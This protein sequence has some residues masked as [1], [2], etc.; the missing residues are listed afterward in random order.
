[1]SQAKSEIAGILPRYPLRRFFRLLKAERRDITYLYT[2]AVLTG[3]ISLSLPLGIQAIVNFV[4]GGQLSTSW[5]IL[6]LLVIVGVIV[7]GFLQIMQLIISETIQQRIFTN[8]A[9]EFAFRIPRMRLEA[10]YKHYAPELVNR[11]FDTLNVQKGLSKILLDLSSSSLQIIFGLILLSFYH[12]LFIFFGLGLILI[13]Y[14]IIRITGPLGFKSSLQESKYKYQVVHWLEEIARSMEVFKMAG[15][16]DLPMTRT[17]NLVV[18]YLGARKSHFRVLLTKYVFL[19]IFKV[20]I[21][22]ALL[23]MGSVLV[24]RNEMNL[25]QLVAAEIVIILIISS[26]EKLIMSVETVYDVLT[27]LEKIGF[28]MDI[29]LESADAKHFVP[30]KP[31]EGLGVNISDLHFA[32]PDSD[33][34]L[35]GLDLELKAGEKLAIMGNGEPG[36][37]L[38]LRLLAGFYDGY[39]GTVTINGIPLRNLDLCNLRGHIGGF[40][41]LQS[42]FDG[43]LLENITLGRG[44]C[45]MEEVLR[46]IEVVGLR[47]YI[48]REPEG[49]EKRIT[50]EE[51]KLP[52]VVYRK[53][54]L[55]RALVAKP[56]LLLLNEPFLRLSEAES[57]GLMEYIA[58]AIPG[59]TVILTLDHLPDAS[60]F[61]RVCTMKNGRI[62]STQK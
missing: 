17:D 30:V 58:K 60:G 2:Y 20:V 62:V 22:G 12:P 59:S 16:P 18:N 21:I 36:K 44:N 57:D 32:L 49:F 47:D 56:N 37:A 27:A 15:P 11:F 33:E 48:D 8:S 41:S 23:I 31:G 13:L 34:I 29:P 51:A 53:I 61:D 38:L 5:G 7:S 43:S 26:V 50:P 54:L 35:T 55:A 10:L 46:I 1:M 9:L 42:V 6:V 45:G 39:S 52:E 40:T 25:G 4:A 14:M 24:V 19:V 28:V 3:F